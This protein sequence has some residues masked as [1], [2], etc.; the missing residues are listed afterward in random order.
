[1][2]TVLKTGLGMALIVTAAAG[3][4]GCNKQEEKQAAATSSNADESLIQFPLPKGA[5][6]YADIDG[7]KM[8]QDVKEQADIARKFRD[9]GHPQYW[10]RLVGTSADKEDV[11]W[12]EGKFHQAGVSDTR[13]QTVKYYDD[14]W[15][16][17]AW[18]LTAVGGGK[19]LKLE[20]AQPA[21]GTPDTGGKEVDL[22]IAYVGLGSDADFAGK[23]I[24]GK[25]VLFIKG[26]NSYQIGAPDIL[27][28]MADGG[29]A[30]VLSADLR[31]GNIKAQAYRANTTVP[32]FDLGTQDALAVRDMIGKGDKP[33]LKFS[34]SAEKIPNSESYIVWATLPGNTDETIYILAHRDGFFDAAGDN[35]AGVAAM[36]GIA[37]HFAK[38]PKEQRRRTMV[39]LGTEG[40][41]SVTPGGYGREWLVANRDTLFAK[42][43]LM[44]NMEHPAEIQT[45]NSVAG[46]TTAS[47]P[48]DWYAGGDARPQLQKIA[49]DAFREFGVNIWDKPSQKP[50]AGELGRFY[51]FLPGVVSQSN[52]YMHMHTE[53]DT[54]EMSPGRGFRP[55]PGLM[56]RSLMK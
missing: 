10:G 44:M 34:L 43:A 46:T 13:V 42:T 8:W 55:S 2:K 33:H 54:P 31:G 32:A 52:D 23:N 36:L 51:Y 14:Q 40:H 39:F 11:Q 56:R 12:L 47:M 7:K 48:L 29:A 22:E 19:S 27:K 15:L 28:R 45:F 38:I 1:M 16:G 21:Y 4:L 6:A 49:G 3:L 53:M 9:N 24:R 50:A 25:A 5:E 26:N 41:H 37:A 30:A 18:S 17:K 20:S 35:A